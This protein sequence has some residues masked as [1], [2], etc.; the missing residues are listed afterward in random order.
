M[1]PPGAAVVVTAIL[2]HSRKPVVRIKG[3]NSSRLLR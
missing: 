1:K 2:Y 3:V